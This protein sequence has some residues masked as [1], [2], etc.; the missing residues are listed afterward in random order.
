MARFLNKDLRRVL[1]V[2]AVIAALGGVFMNLAL[3]GHEKRMSQRHY[4]ALARMVEAV[5]IEYPAVSEEDVIKAITSGKTMED[6]KRTL[7]QYGIFAE[8]GPSARWMITS[9][10]IVMILC[11][12][13]TFLLFW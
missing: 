2:M 10:G 5:K 1:S 13:T 9:I 4:E 6:G 11:M 8:K 3:F 12:I 7:T